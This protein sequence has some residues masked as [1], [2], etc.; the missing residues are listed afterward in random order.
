MNFYPVI[1]TDSIK[2]LQNQVDLVK[3][4][5]GI[6]TVQIDIIDGFFVDNVTV[7]PSD[8][9]DVDFGD[10]TID[11]HMMTEEPIDYVHE[12]LE[13]KDELPIRSV[14]GQIEKMSYQRFFLEEVKKHEWK[15]GLS[16]DIFTPVEEIDEEVWGMLDIVQLMGIESGEQGKKL[17]NIIFDKVE[18]V[19]SR[20]PSFAKAS[21]GKGAENSFEIMVDGG[22]KLDNAQK[23]VDAGVEGLVVGS[24]IWGAED[25][26]E[27]V[28][29]FLAVGN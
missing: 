1:L 19:K 3:D 15:A 18:Q 17:K 26:E 6:E 21:A 12:F 16:I 13:R 7:T 10:L 9:Y 5:E 11:L 29:E 28:K 14:I 2:T 25:T 27:V 24:A 4:I 8:L 22:V 23:L 20:R